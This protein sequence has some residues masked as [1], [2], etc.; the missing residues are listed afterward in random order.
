MSGRPQE[1]H[2]NGHSK[3]A[4]QC[5][6]HH[7]A[8]LVN[9][10]LFDPSSALANTAGGTV[11]PS[12]AS[13]G[14]LR[15]TISPARSNHSLKALQSRLRRSPDGALAKSGN[16]QPASICQFVGGHEQTGHWGNVWI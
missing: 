11:R 5:Q 14:Y 7:F 13:H 3:T 8:L 4:A 15:P 12:A 6:S 16:G 1:R 2:K 9:Q 10:L